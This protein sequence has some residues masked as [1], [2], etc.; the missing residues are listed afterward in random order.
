MSKRSS[1][2][3]IADNRTP[4]VHIEYDVETGEG[5]EKMELPFV[6]GVLAD[7]SGKPEEALP[8]VDDVEV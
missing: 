8:A 4:R 7:L 6:M 1:Q 3:F 2:K 5:I